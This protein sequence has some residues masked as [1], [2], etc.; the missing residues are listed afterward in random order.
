MTP[1]SS[2]I[3]L[4]AVRKG[5][6]LPL[7]GSRGTVQSVF[8]RALNVEFPD[9]RG[10]K[11]LF[12]VLAPGLPM[13]SWGCRLA[14]LPVPFEDAVREGQPCS[15]DGNVLCVGGC[16]SVDLSGAAV[17]DGGW[18]PPGKTI[19]E[20]GRL[21]LCRF[22]HR[23]KLPGFLKLFAPFRP[24]VRND[25]ILSAAGEAAAA[26][27]RARSA[28][29]ASGE[30]AAA[31]R[32]IGLGPG[33]TPAGDD[34]LGGYLAGRFGQA[35][36]GSMDAGV[37]KFTSLLVPYAGTTGTVAQAFLKKALA[38]NFSEYIADLARAAVSGEADEKQILELAEK[39]LEFGATSGAD[40]LAGFL[41][42]CFSAVDFPFE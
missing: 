28:R 11:T 2:P 12:V 31:C 16:L 32:L 34:F 39:V 10:E 5:K 19:G 30:A 27:L 42:S 4:T 38:G 17:W 36:G 22:A 25:I 1:G 15:F 29:D 24:S 40:A 41:T 23:K 33:L 37:L 20:A 9:A 7:P 35:P 8:R 26:M 6:D 18:L 14:E 21:A 13:A 3:V